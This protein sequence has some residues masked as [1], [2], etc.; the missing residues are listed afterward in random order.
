MKLF[1]DDREFYKKA[2]VIAIPIAL[3][4]AI[5]IG[6][7]LADTIMVGTLGETTLSATALANQFVSIFQICCMGLGMGA[8]VLTSRYWGMKDNISLKKAVT[9]MLRLCTLLAIVFFTIPTIFAPESLMR[10][11]TGDEAVIAEGIRY[12]K[13]MI[14]CYLLQGLALTSTIVLRSVGQAKIPLYSAIGAFF[15]NIFF[16]WIFIFGKLGMPR[17]GIEGAGAGTV[18]A[19]TFEF[20]TV[21]GYMFVMDKNMKYRFKDIFMP[22]KDLLK[23]YITISLPVLISDTLLALGNSAV[24]MVMGHIGRNFVSANSITVV[25]QQLS[26]VLIQGICQAS[27]IMTGHSLG[28]GNR[29]KTMAQAW[30][31]L[32][33]AMVVGFVGAVII[34]VISDPVIACYNITPETEAIAQELMF[35][36]AFIVVFQSMNSILTKGVLRGGGDT[37]FLMAADIL[38]LWIMS[39]PLGALAGLVWDLDAFWV[40][41]FLKIDQ[42]V[43]SVWCIFRLRSGKWIKT[44]NRAGQAA[45][46]PM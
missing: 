35:S 32:G 37:K 4:S 34:I 28:E 7:N 6:V 42:V 2:A 5:S 1:V 14:P 17:M 38:F 29:E 3:Q 39:I 36:I 18:I 43:K 26:T 40:Y 13:W 30:T 27:C 41:F 21:C 15:V 25:T 46:S 20:V 10:L 8:S 11:Y 16:N 12:F 24:A 22:C 44:I 31:F 23:T 9:L 33:L 19:R 45:D